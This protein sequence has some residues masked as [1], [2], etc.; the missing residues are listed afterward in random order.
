MFFRNYRFNLNQNGLELFKL[1]F[2]LLDLQLQ[3]LALFLFV[4]FLLA[5]HIHYA[6]YRR[7]SGFD[8][9]YDGLRAYSLIGSPPKYCQS[10]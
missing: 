9:R 6:R 1:A 2:S 5:E 10:M 4:L 8:D 7:N 3:I